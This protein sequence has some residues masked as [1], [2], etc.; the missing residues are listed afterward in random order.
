MYLAVFP[1]PE[2][3]L[4]PTPGASSRKNVLSYPLK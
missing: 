3:N 2:N 1:A 4:V